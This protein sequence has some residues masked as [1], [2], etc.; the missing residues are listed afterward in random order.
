MARDR[1]IYP[2]IFDYAVDGISIEFPD[3][4]GCLPCADS[5][6]A[7]IKNAQE[8]MALHLYGMEQDGDEIPEPTPITEIHH[9]ENQAIVLVEV[10]MPL[11]RNVIESRAV[12]KTLTVPKWLNDLAEEKQ[13]NFSHLLQTALKN[14]LGVADR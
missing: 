6:E 2:A 14:H 4:P 12:K 11:Y 1:Y 10:W 3:L 9:G 5:T 7:A 13:V 8:A